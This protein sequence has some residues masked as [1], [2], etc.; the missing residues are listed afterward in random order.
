M[1]KGTK[2]MS[3][4]D[5]EVG[6]SSSSMM[7]VAEDDSAEGNQNVHN[8][9][10]NKTTMVRQRQPP[11]KKRLTMPNVVSPLLSLIADFQGAQTI[12]SIFDSVARKSIFGLRKQDAPKVRK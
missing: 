11:A 2:H 6:S 3:L 7:L 10:I 9:P 4:M 8:K 5:A 12:P 1:R